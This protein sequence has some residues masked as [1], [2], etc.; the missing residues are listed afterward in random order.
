VDEKKMEGWL[1]PE[2]FIKVAESITKLTDRVEKLLS[3]FESVGYIKGVISSSI[4]D[5]VIKV[6]YPGK[7][8]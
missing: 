4:G 8:K 5:I 3:V 7:D 1:V 2:S 6:Y